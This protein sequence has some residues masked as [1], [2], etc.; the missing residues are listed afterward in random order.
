MQVDRTG[1]DDTPSGVQLLL[2]GTMNP[3]ADHSDLA[4]LDGYVTMK[5]G[6]TPS[7]IDNRTVSDYFIE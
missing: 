7:P 1:S 4:I 2:G 5:G 3:P 6:G